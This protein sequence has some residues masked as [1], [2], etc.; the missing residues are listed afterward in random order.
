MPTTIT[1]DPSDIEP[2]AA[3]AAE[4][5]FTAETAPWDPSVR[6][7]RLRIEVSHRS[8][9]YIITSCGSDLRASAAVAAE[10]AAA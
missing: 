3:E 6:C 5:M 7:L 4:I 8:R 10:A 1:A 9:G 2:G